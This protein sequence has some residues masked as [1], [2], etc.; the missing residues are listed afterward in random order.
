MRFIIVTSLLALLANVFQVSLFEAIAVSYLMLPLVAFSVH[1]IVGVGP[2]TYYI[3][4]ALVM[5][6]WCLFVREPD[7]ARRPPLK[8]RSEGLIAFLTLFLLCYSLALCWPDFYPTGERMRDY[9]LIGSVT[10]SPFEVK[11]SWFAGNPLN[12]YAYWYRFGAA[13]ASMLH[14]PVWM[15]YHLLQSVTFSLF[16][17]SLYVLAR[18]Y[19]KYSEFGAAITALVIMF[20]SNLEGIFNYVTRE[21]NWWTP[22]RVINGAINEFPAW[23]FLL[24]DLHPHFLN[25]VLAPLCILIALLLKDHVVSLPGR[26]VSFVAFAILPILFLFNTNAWEIPIWMALCGSLLLALMM[27]AMMRLDPDVFFKTVFPDRRLRF[28]LK[29]LAGLLCIVF[30]G[31]ALYVASLNL[32]PPKYAWKFVGGE[33]PGSLVL[34]FLKHWG[35][36]LAAIFT[37]IIAGLPAL[38][39]A[40]FVVL[41]VVS[42]IFSVSIFPLLLVLIAAHVTRMLLQARASETPATPLIMLNALGL[43]GLIAITTPELIFL[44]D[45]YGGDN[46][47]MN[48]IFKFYSAGWALINLFAIGIVVERAQA[49]PM[50]F[51][52]LIAG[53]AAFVLCLFFMRTVPMRIGSERADAEG[54]GTVERQFSGSTEAIRALRDAP[55]GVVLETQGPA[56]NWTSFVSTLANQ[57]AFLGWANHINV[58]T[59]EYDEVKRR[60][61]LT[62]EFYTTDSC[63]TRKQIMKDENIQYAVVG[64]LERK[65][66]PEVSGLDFS[67]LKKFFGNAEVVI[68][69]R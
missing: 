21:G 52:R 19:F 35:I 64:H 41:A 10:R 2:F 12:Y 58:L 55:P 47:R 11:E 54:L 69:E 5:L 60:E 48:T 38:F 3:L 66:H 61:A 17:A 67:C 56:Y 15:T 57:D 16:G 40:I 49:R 59:H 68:W 9:A 42:L 32:E 13:L 23:S 30:I 51:K 44:D 4:L 24:G 29:F 7:A 1:S 37:G 46:E 8:E 50:W 65:E 45:P 36:P 33:V 6:I 20:G 62:Q 22:S 34:E 53:S 26:M 31:G 27:P 14:L 43:A 39:A 63:E 18:R 28:S 25:L